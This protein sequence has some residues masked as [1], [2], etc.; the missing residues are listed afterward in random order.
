MLLIPEVL[1]ARNIRLSMILEVQSNY[2]QSP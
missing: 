1:P 2:Y